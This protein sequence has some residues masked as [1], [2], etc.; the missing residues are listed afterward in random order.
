MCGN[1]LQDDDT[2]NKYKYRGGTSDATAWLF[3]SLLMSF[4]DLFTLNKAGYTAQDAPSMRTFHLR[5]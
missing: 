1:K 3:V 2:G 4:D 5:K